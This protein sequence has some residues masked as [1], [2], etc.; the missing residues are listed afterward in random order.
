MPVREYLCH[1][2]GFFEERWMRHADD[3]PPPCPACGDR[4][5]EQLMSRF[6][7]PFMGSLAKYTDQKRE[8]AGMEG[9]WAYR[10]RSSIS[11]NPEPV[12]IDSMA[13]LKE[14]NKVEGLAAP[15][16]IP[17]NSTISADG[18]RIISNGMPGQW[19]CGLPEMPS[20]LREMVS[21]PAEECHPLA[22]SSAPFTVSGTRTGNDV[23]L[24]L[25]PAG[26]EPIALNAFFFYDH[27]LRGALTGGGFAGDSVLLFRQ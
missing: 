18:R 22:A 7:A 2:C 4:E 26:G 23:S 10:K 1:L 17:T 14:F 3:P 12:Y 25:R 5:R 8:N 24:T 11:G 13:A 19:Q 15:G 20:R 27:V 9:F 16:E 21:T 6:A